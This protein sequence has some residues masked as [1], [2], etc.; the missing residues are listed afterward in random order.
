MNESS[1]IADIPDEN[2]EE[3]ILVSKVV[4]C[5][6]VGMLPR[7][8]STNFYR[9]S[10]SAISSGVPVLIT[11]ELKERG[12]ES[13]VT[14]NCEKMTISSILAKELVAALKKIS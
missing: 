13:K 6:S 11:V 4:G 10:G 7:N 5:A 12:K 1:L 8:T 3:R 9:F 2:C 14:V